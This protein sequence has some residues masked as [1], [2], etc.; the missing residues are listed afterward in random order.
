MSAA[1][2]RA[3]LQAQPGT[4]TYAAAA[5][6]LGL[7]PPGTIAQ[8]AALLETLMAEDAAAGRPFLAARVVSRATG[9]PAPGFY[10][11]AA[12]LGRADVDAAAERAALSGA[13]EAPKPPA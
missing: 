8:V 1:R 7:Q 9:A 12:R 4:V 5:A 2:L 13:P 11:T 10:Q 6:A 3:W